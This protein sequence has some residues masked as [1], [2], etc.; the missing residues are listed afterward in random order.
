MKSSFLP[1]G[2]VYKEWHQQRWM[3]VLFL[4]AT[5]LLPVFGS[6]A[7]EFV[8]LTGHVSYL[9]PGLSEGSLVWFS[10]TVLVNP[11]GY[12]IGLAPWGAA[13]LLGAA[14]WSAERRGNNLETVLAS[15]V[16]KAALVRV[17]WLLGTATIFAVNLPGALL[18]WLEARGAGLDV[19]GMTVSADV[20]LGL[21][22][23]WYSTQVGMEW[24]IFSLAFVAAIGV[25]R[26]VMSILWAALVL[27]MPLGLTAAVTYLMQESAPW[28]THYMGKGM[29]GYATPDIQALSPVYGTLQ[30]WVMTLNPESYYGTFS[31]FYMPQMLDFVLPVGGVLSI[32]LYVASLVL[33]EHCEME[34]FRRVFC[35]RGFAM[36]SLMIVG[37]V[38]AWM[39]GILQ[40]SSDVTAHLQSMF[41]HQPWHGPAPMLVFTLYFAGTVAVEVLLWTALRRFLRSRQARRE[42]V[43]AVA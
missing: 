14:L 21:A 4:I 22:A 15:P 20:W 40:M 30:N 16:S 31:Y 42:H 24:L 27:F 41:D 18:L 34:R 23:R 26:Y 7:Q 8:V 32:L 39:L 36:S 11:S 17:K 6:I 10:Q 28:I 43:M 37:V 3:I 35:L 33:F 1:R 19:N 12:G 38:P 13:L 25:G 29:A 5:W 9:G 2:L